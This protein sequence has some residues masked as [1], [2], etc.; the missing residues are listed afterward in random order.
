M[1]T[2]YSK[3]QKLLNNS[4][5]YEQVLTDKKVNGIIQY[6]T[7]DFGILTFEELN[8]MNYTFHKFIAGDKLYN[9]SQKYYNSPEYGWLIC[10][11]NGIKSELDIEEEQGLRIYFPLEKILGLINVRR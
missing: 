10:Y 5:I 4:E 1:S 6:S 2:R 3:T 8:K 7:F 11:T 9:I